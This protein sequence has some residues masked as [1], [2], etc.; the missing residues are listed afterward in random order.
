MS[1]DSTWGV[2]LQDGGRLSL[3]P[4]NKTESWACFCNKTTQIITKI[5]KKTSTSLQLSVSDKLNNVTKTAQI[6]LL[7]MA[8]TKS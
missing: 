4:L 7:C 2:L 8:C 1:I 6:T 3:L 5:A